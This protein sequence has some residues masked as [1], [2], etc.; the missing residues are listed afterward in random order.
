MKRVEERK[1]NQQMINNEVSK[2]IEDIEKSKEIEAEKDHRILALEKTI[3]DNK[4]EITTLVKQ[5]VNFFFFCIHT[6]N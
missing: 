1:P 3:A 2:L 4:S 5:M 6:I